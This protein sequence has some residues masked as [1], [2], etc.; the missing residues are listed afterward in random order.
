M[1]S[2]YSFVIRFFS[3]PKRMFKRRQFKKSATFVEGLKTVNIGPT[4]FCQNKTGKKDNI[5]IGHHCDIHA[6]IIAAGNDGRI[7]IGNYTTIR[8]GYIGSV[9]SIVIGNHV[10]ISNNVTIYDN[11]NHPTDPDSR[12]LMC[13]SG[14]YS[15]L[16]NWE[17][18]V[19]KPVVIEDNVWIGE[20]STILKGVTIGVGSIVAAHSVVTKDVEPYTIV[21]GN[22]AKTVKYLK[23]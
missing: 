15:D 21:A 5:K 16:W 19:H 4:A 7:N 8:G 6:R 3:F 10:I 13:E 1:S 20:H 9:E 2:I 14:F 12:K 22:P 18:S 17:N 23:G 11:N